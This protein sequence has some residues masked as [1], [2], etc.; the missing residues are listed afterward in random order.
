MLFLDEIADDNWLIAVIDVRLK[1]VDQIV[2]FNEELFSSL[3]IEDFPTASIKIPWSPSRAY[4]I[5]FDL[6]ETMNKIFDVIRESISENFYRIKIELKLSSRVSVKEIQDQKVYINGDTKKY[7]Y[8]IMQQN[9]DF[10]RANI[11]MLGID[12]KDAIGRKI[13]DVLPES[14]LPIVLRSGSPEIR[15]PSIKKDNSQG[16]Y[17]FRSCEHD[18]K[19]F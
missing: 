15:V 16:F 13:L 8:L 12:P 1:N 3:F 6:L 4:S 7:Y 18:K 10:N 14:R 11:D 5:Q 19:C 9:L 17:D 2:Y